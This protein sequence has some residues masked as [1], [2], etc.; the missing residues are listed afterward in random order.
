MD[1]NYTKIYMKEPIN[2]YV[3]V[4]FTRFF[5]AAGLW[6]THETILC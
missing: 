6:L 2:F 5:G 4:N 1:Q 3:S